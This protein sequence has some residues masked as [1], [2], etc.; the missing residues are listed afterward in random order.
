MH[1]VRC[2]TE[3]STE[4]YEGVFLE[5]CYGC[6]GAFVPQTRL[7]AILESREQGWTEAQVEGFRLLREQPG[8]VVHE[9]TAEIAC[10]A[11]G[12]AMKQSRYLY[13]RE[14]IIDRCPQGC[15]L[16]LDDGE[17]EHVQMAVEEEEGKLNALVEEHG[18]EVSTHESEQLARE[19]RAY[20]L[21][22]WDYFHGQGSS[23]WRGRRFDG[24]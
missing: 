3:L 18:L 9:A 2:D 21:R 17:L 14:V 6:R 24:S 16:W 1:C 5:R 20:Q 13:A 15:G 8:A 19:K 7:A 23:F 22:I 11:C 10:P 12:E 4:A